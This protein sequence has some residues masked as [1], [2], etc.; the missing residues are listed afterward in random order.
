MSLVRSPSIG[1]PLTATT[2]NAASLRQRLAV[3]PSRAAADPLAGVEPTFHQRVAHAGLA[4]LM[5][6][7][8]NSL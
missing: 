6:S 3:C 8:I 4:P 7:A 1:Y 2:S 5:T